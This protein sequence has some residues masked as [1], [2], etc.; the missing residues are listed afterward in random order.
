M[1]KVLG[2]DAD[3]P[4]E[5]PYCS[6]CNDYDY[7][8]GRCECLMEIYRSLQA[9]SLS[10]LLDTGPN[11]FSD[12]SLSWYPIEGTGEL[13]PRA[14]MTNVLSFCKLYAEKFQKGSRNLFFSGSTGLGK[15]FLSACIAKTALDRGFSV[16]YDTASSIF[17]KY[18]AA[19]FSV[20][21]EKDEARDSIERIK[22][23]DLLII[24]DLG[25][26]F[27]TALTVSSFYDIVNS[28]ITSHGSVIIN[29]NLSEN[30][31]ASKYSQQIASRLL[32]E[33]K[34]FHFIG[35][36]IRALKNGVL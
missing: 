12:F 15:T 3:Y 16:I 4:D 29:S 30:E 21:D 26:E 23:C 1:L 9:K 32:G 20:G 11:D 10:S 25:T 14:Y 24:D 17:A 34:I 13:S 28:R 8:S 36:D 35:N 2:Y 5:K 22:A 6:I 33:F 19:R 18:E 31:I 27:T 7:S